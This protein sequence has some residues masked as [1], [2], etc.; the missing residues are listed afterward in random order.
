MA[1]FKAE[2]EAALPAIWRYAFA[3]T[4]DHARAD[5]LVQD[6]VERALNKRH[7]WSADR[8]L[9]P[10]LA[11]IALNVFRN[12]LHRERA[13]LHLAY[14]EAGDTPDLPVSETHMDARL[15]AKRTLARVA[16]LPEEQRH[17]LLLVTVG[18]LSY[19]ET[20]EALGVPIG[21][22]MSRIARARHRLKQDPQPV[23]LRSVT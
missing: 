10:W 22:V 8:P 1:K 21:T 20:A 23:Q 18:G 7:L 6:C 19:A 2:L 9:R 14:D 4:R 17:A 16:Q 5:D 3:L 15:D 13:H 11:K 12:G